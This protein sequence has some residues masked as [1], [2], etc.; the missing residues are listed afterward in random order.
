MTFNPKALRISPLEYHKVCNEIGHERWVCEKS[1]RLQPLK[2][3]QSCNR[4]QANDKFD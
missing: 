2:L 4:D 3:L 1:A